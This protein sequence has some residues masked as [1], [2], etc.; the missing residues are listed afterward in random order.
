MYALSGTVKQHAQPSKQSG[1]VLLVN[2][3]LQVNIVL[4]VIVVGPL[5]DINVIF[6]GVFDHSVCLPD[7]M[8]DLVIR[9]A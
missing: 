6:L 7:L 4:Q 1:L 8:L 5:E 9:W 3:V 2:V